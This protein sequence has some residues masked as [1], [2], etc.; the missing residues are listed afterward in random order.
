MRRFTFAIAFATIVFAGCRAVEPPIHLRIDGS[1]PTRGR[2]LVG[3]VGCG[4]CHA[5][6]HVTGAHGVVGPPL[7]YF[8]RRTVL[9]GHLPNVPRTLVPFLMDP[10]ALR[11]DTAMPNVGLQIGAARDIAAFLYTL[12]AA[13]TSSGVPV[14]PL[15][16]GSQSKADAPLALGAARP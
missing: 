16:A 10:P 6:P 9:A 3:E 13:G 2:R 5:I 8:A 11:P 12:G 4:A 14:L 15:G 7:Q 1:D